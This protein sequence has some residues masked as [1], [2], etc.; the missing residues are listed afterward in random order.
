VKKTST[1]SIRTLAAGLSVLNCPEPRV[2]DAAP[3][4]PPD[5]R[6]DYDLSHRAKNTHLLEVTPAMC[7]GGTPP[8]D[9]P[10]SRAK[11]LIHFNEAYK[12]RVPD[13]RRNVQTGR[14]HQFVDKIHSQV[15]RGS[16][17]TQS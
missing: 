4:R 15:L 5:P 13:L 1:G 17:I 14:R 8:L 12:A 9:C 16:T 11:M 10:I 7:E 3:I 6:T 2:P